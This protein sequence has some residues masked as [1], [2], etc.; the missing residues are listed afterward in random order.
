MPKLH[1]GSLTC[2]EAQR[3]SLWIPMCWRILPAVERILPRAK[4]RVSAL[5]WESQRVDPQNPFQELP[6]I[7]AENSQ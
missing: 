1:K 4:F 2:N 5:N 6:R 3:E 7:T